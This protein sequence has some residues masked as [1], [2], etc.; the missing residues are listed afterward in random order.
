MSEKKSYVGSLKKRWKGKMAS[1]IK[2]GE[3]TID[4]EEVNR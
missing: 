2:R 1:N 3:K 4:K